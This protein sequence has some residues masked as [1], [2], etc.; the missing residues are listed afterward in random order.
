MGGADAAEG[1][2]GGGTSCEAALAA[3]KKAGGFSARAAEG[4]SGG[5]VGAVPRL[6]RP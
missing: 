1:R 5:R 3:S 2:G 4:E 6:L